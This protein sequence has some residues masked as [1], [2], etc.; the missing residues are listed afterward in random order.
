MRAVVLLLGV[1]SE[2]RGDLDNADRSYRH[3]LDEDPTLAQAHKNL[4]DQALLRHGAAHENPRFRVELPD[5][6]HGF[7]ASELPHDEVHRHQ[8]RPEQLVLLDRFTPVFG[9][10]DDVESPLFEDPSHELSHI[11]GVV[12]DQDRLIGGQC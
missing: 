12:A 10:A 5:G 11:W 8:V 7:D 6:P 2:R 9:F 1:I 4:G 3:A